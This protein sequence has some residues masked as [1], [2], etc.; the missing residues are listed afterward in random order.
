ML[1][2]LRPLVLLAFPLLSLLRAGGHAFG[3]FSVD[4]AGHL[5]MGWRA[6][7][8]EPTRTR[9]L[10]WPEGVDLMPV[11]G[12]WLD[13][14]LVGAASHAL[15]LE[16]AYN[17][18]VALYL[19]VAG[20]GGWALARGLGVSSGVALLAGL[21]LQI[22]GFVLQHLAGGRPEQVGLGF[23][24]L[25]LAGAVGGLRGRWHP[26]AVGLSGLPLLFVSWELSLLTVLALVWM[27]PFCWPHRAPDALRRLVLGALTCAALGLPW[28][29][30]FLL[31]AGSVR[32]VDEGEFAL[33]TA[34]RAS[35][36]LLSWFSPGSFRPGWLT[37]A[38]LGTLAWRRSWAGLG[39]ALG[40]VLVLAL[41][42][43]P[44]PGLWG[45]GPGAWGPFAWLQELP[46]L[47]WFHWPDR[48][49]AL[50]S[51]AAAVCVAWGLDQLAR[52]RAWVPLLGGALCLGGGLA[53][54][55]WAE[56]LPRGQFHLETHPGAAWLAQGEGAVLD[57]P[58][59]PEPQHHL[60][61]MLLQIEHGRP[62]LFNMVLDHLA[63]EGLSAR[64]EQDPVLAWFQQLMER[65]APP[66]RGFT[67]QE[68]A[69]LRA[70]GF[71]VVVLHQQGWPRE[72][73]EL[74][75]EVLTASLGEPS[76]RMGEQ[77][78]A[79]DLQGILPAQSE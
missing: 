28:V 68:L 54:Q 77:W 9:L 43:G 34:R 57:L 67:A 32:A 41:A 73:W 27:A 18:V 1:R 63:D 31:R 29:L 64:V 21:L 8:E 48:L 16:W 24:A 79:W 36:G 50:W 76:F 60:R 7:F 58:I 59:Q 10:A 3:A 44:G 72:R 75:R 69:G 46:V 70:Q 23:V 39:V 40:L 78:L 74:A 56:R 30:L 52:G 25:A 65:E 37:L 55:A 6:G 2:R 71:T 51:I 19:V 62:I 20:L 4:L 42:L 45:P 22:D 35:V 49:L 5:W 38:G 66:Q 17:L 15:P 26:V 33:E 47:G 11:L 53:E 12:G 13:V 14:W 61:Y